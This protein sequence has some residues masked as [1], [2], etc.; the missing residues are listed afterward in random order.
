[1]RDLVFKKECTY[2]DFLKS[3]EKIATNILVTRLKML[4]EN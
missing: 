2:G 1:V 4:E 3:E